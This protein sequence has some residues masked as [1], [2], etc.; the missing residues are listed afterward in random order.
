[1]KTLSYRALD[2]DCPHSRATSLRA[3]AKPFRRESL[4]HLVI[5]DEA[6]LR[7]VLKNPL[8]SSKAMVLLRQ[9]IV[10]NISNR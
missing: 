3:A 5:F 10:V 6:Q 7:R 8:A 1:L 2:K 9:H 4:E